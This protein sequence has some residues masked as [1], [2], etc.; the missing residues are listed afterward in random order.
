[1]EKFDFSKVVLPVAIILGFIFRDKIQKILSFNITSLAKTEQVNITPELQ[2]KRLMK[3]IVWGIAS[4]VLIII[5]AIIW[6]T[7]SNNNSSVLNGSYK[8]ENNIGFVETYL[9]IKENEFNKKE[10]S[11]ENC[12]IL[13]KWKVSFNNEKNFTIVDSVFSKYELYDKQLNK[14]IDNEEQKVFFSG[15][16]INVK[17]NITFTEDKRLLINTDDNLMYER[18][19]KIN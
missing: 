5:G 14:C 6:G 19:L 11:K 9:D 8:L 10:V 13:Q 7:L 2:K 16:N 12:H 1:M 3:I 15:K 18:Y 17:L 4:C